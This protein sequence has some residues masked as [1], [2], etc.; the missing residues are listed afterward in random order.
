MKII[1]L[2][3]I[4]AFS[5]LTLSSAAYAGTNTNTDTILGTRPMQ[6]T[7]ERAVVL[8]GNV[9]SDN[10]ATPEGI[11]EVQYAFAH[12]RTSLHQDM[13]RFKTPVPAKELY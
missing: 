13:L 2:L 5:A 1:N 8:K 12:P 11:A 10:V 9:E 6:V 7:I 3:T 4:G